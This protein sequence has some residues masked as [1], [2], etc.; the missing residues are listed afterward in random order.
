MVPMKAGFGMLQNP[1]LNNIAT[2]SLIGGF[3]AGCAITLAMVGLFAK[4]ND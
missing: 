1:E 2:G 4:F 3:V